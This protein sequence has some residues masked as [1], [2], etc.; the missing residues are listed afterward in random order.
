V[1]GDFSK[2]AALTRHGIG[3]LNEN[4][5][6]DISFNPE[7][8]GQVRSVA[9]Q[10]DGKILLGG[11]FTSMNGQARRGIARLTSGSVALRTLAINTAGTAATWNRSG[12]GPEVEQVIFESSTDS[13]N[14]TP[15]GNA[16]RIPDGWQLTGLSIQSG[17][18]FYL[19]A[20]GR[21]TSGERNGSSGL[22]ESVAQF[23][24]L[25][26]PFISSVQVLGGGVFQFSFTN[27][28]AVLFS[29]LASGDVAAPSASWEN[30]GAP[31]YVGNSLY[32]FTDPGATNHARRFYQLRSP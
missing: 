12:A 6:P 2:L 31:V 32:Q 5:S 27:R 3:R 4:G 18:P 24:R 17:L 14:Y 15:L 7:A 22:I 16:V 1:V 13:T 23:W 19:R 30:L 11:F 25:P 9:I 20:R 10:S 26:P 8:A 28:N 21:T 29:V